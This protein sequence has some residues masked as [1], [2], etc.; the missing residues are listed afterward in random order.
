M[1][2]RFPRTPL[3]AFVVSIA[4]VAGCSQ[5]APEDD[6]AS[7]QAADRARQTVPFHLVGFNDFHGHLTSPAG[8]IT[9]DGEEIEAGGAAQLAGHIE[10]FRREHSNTAT[11][12]AGDLIGASPLVSALFHDEPT[13]EI[14]NEIG[15]AAV[16]V[17]NHEF[18]EG[19][20]ELLRIADGGCHPEDGCR[21]GR[22]SYEGA[23]FPYLAANVERPDGELL[24]DPYVVREYDGVKVG[25]LGLTLDGLP[26][27]VVPSAVEGLRFRN[28]W[29]TINEY[30]PELQQKGVETIIVL[31]HEGGVPSEPPDGLDGCGDLEGPIVEIAEKSDDAVDAFVSG[32]TH[33][34]YRCRIDDKLVTSANSHGLL[35]TEY[36]FALD[37]ETGDVV[38]MSA[39]NVPIRADGP[40]DEEIA[41]RVEDYEKRAADR[42]ERTVGSIRETLARD[43]MKT[44]EMHLGRVIADA[45]LEAT[46]A[47]EAGGAQVA[48]MNPGGIRGSLPHDGGETTDVTYGDLHRIQP[49]RNQLVVMTLTGRQLHAVLEHQWREDSHPKILQVSEGFSYTWNPNAEVGD[50][51]E[52]AEVRIDGEP[53]DLEADY[54]VTVN[55]FL[56]EGGDGFATLEEGEDR[57]WGPIDLEAMVDYF[58]GHSPISVPDEPR[59]RRAD[60]ESDE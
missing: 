36:D 57:V 51:V 39:T 6:D 34:T 44:G 7:Q 21:E 38:E 27:I 56:A 45:Q 31:I 20:K 53:L 49:F 25:F 4:L 11:V 1:P 24:F 3:V 42:S 19:W 47:D 18:D 9:V 40:V 23:E 30:V 46:S 16:P 59:I 14:M 12:V 41:S 10:Q 60:T 37:P 52:P 15:L 58:E 22:D 5:P 50:R 48:L 35:V 17:G 43:P 33:K 8:K 26:S 2:Y 28:E 55:N 29:K 13:I 32:H 54:R